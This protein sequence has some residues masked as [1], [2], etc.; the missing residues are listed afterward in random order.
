MWNLKAKSKETLIDGGAERMR[1]L[2]AQCT[3]AA[4]GRA[5]RSSTYTPQNRSASTQATLCDCV[6]SVHNKH[7]T[8]QLSPT[9]EEATTEPGRN[10]GG[11]SVQTT[12]TLPQTTPRV[13]PCLSCLVSPGDPPELCGLGVPKTPPCPQAWGLPAAPSAPDPTRRAPQ[14]SMTY[15]TGQA[16]FHL[17][18]GD[19]GAPK[20]P[21]AGGPQ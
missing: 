19:L 18:D 8:L 9:S 17:R 12:P 15:A 21:T 14:G 2:K 5:V 13:P 11:R 16:G 6:R 7:H 3:E 1:K 20:W 4:T 10:H